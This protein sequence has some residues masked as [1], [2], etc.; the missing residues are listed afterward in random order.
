VGRRSCRRGAR[1]SC[2]SILS[3]R[4]LLRWPESA[5]LGRATW[6]HARE[7][8]SRAHAGSIGPYAGSP[9]AP[10]SG[11]GGRLAPPR[12]AF[13]YP[14]SVLSPPLCNW[15]QAQTE[16]WKGGVRGVA[17][18]AELQSVRGFDWAR[19]RGRRG[20]RRRADAA[21]LRLRLAPPRSASGTKHSIHTPHCKHCFVL[22]PRAYVD[23]NVDQAGSCVRSRVSRPH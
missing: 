22:A 16:S 11:E 23:E 2:P 8:G 13:G 20:C 10:R 15:L 19:A 9:G 14:A 12:G 18:R 7:R 21:V 5:G 3:P 17:Q 6:S 1:R 4:F